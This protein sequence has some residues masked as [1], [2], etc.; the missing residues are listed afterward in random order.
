MASHDLLKIGR[1]IANRILLT[2]GN[3][4]IK[5]LLFPDGIKL[6]DGFR[7]NPKTTI[8]KDLHFSKSLPS[9][10]LIYSLTDFSSADV[11]FGFS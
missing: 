4:E 9:S 3:K 1:V 8:A 7:S 2:K 10:A 11:N 5:L 6:P